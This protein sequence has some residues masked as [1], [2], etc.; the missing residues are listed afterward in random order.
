M[1]TNSILRYFNSPSRSIICKQIQS[2]QNKETENNE[3]E[4]NSTQLDNNSVDKSLKEP[5]LEDSNL[6]TKFRLNNYLRN[7]VKI[8][9]NN[10]PYNILSYFKTQKC[11]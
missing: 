4:N 1:K 5:Q 8:K 6:E 3:R 7:M 2:N 11:I 9:T 10:P